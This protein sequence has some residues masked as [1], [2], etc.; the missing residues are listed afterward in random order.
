MIDVRIRRI[1]D[2]VT[3]RD[4]RVWWPR[5]RLV[6]EKHRS[7][8]AWW[9]VAKSRTR[10][11][12]SPLGWVVTGWPSTTAVVTVFAVRAWLGE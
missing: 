11:A 6:G 3:A 12:W 7:C 1:E 4:R 2:V 8:L 10:M 5:R 9:A